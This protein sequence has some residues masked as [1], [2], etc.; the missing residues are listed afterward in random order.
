MS[1]SDTIRGYIDLMVLYVL[2]EEPSY[3]YQISKDISELTEDQYNIKNTT[4]YS[5]LERLVKKG[6]LESFHG[7]ETNGKQRTYYKITTEGKKGYYEKCREWKKTNQIIE[8]FL[9][10][11][12]NNGYDSSI[13]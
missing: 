10:E 1:L 11:G 3:G 7:T 2:Y 5:A 9:R 13:Y 8:H 6:D 4:L 12:E